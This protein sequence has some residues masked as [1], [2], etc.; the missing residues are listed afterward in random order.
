[1]PREGGGFDLLRLARYRR[2]KLP[3]HIKQL[4]F[5]SH[6]WCTVVGQLNDFSGHTGHDR[7]IILPGMIGSAG[8]LISWCLII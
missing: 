8:C 5:Q 6:A 2:V 4:G 1:M 7:P 3:Q